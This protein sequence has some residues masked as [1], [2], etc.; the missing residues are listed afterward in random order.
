M[1]RPAGAV[2]ALLASLTLLL[3]SVAGWLGAG[4]PGVG[5]E[6]PRS[7]AGAIG[8]SADPSSTDRAG[9]GPGAADAPGSDPRESQTGPRSV[10]RVDATVIEP[11]ESPDPPRSLGIPSVGVRMPVVA[12]GVREDGQMELPEDPAEVGWYRFGASPGDQRGSVVLGGHVDS[13]RYGVGPLARLASVKAGDQILVT[14]ADG[15]RLRYRVT[16][17]ERI[18]KAALPTERLFDPDSPHR[19]VVITCGGRYLP[20]AGGYEDNIVVVARPL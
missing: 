11:L 5:T 10:P 19:L 16:A 20:D 2:L 7:A 3:G 13:V 14:G 6:L 4:S 15:E 8:E 9:T 18:S 12:T 1:R 17:L